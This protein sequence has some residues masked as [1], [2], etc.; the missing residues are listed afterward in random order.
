MIDFCKKAGA[1]SEPT[2]IRWLTHMDS[3]QFKGCGFV[4]FAT[5]EDAD[6][7]VAH[8]GEDI[9]RRSTRIDYA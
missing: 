8:N 9:L 3:G 2:D 5:V 6:A 7:V 1:A 4:Q